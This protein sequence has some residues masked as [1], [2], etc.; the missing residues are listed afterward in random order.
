MNRKT[1]ILIVTES[2]VP[3]GAETVVLDLAKNIDRDRFNV[4][5]VLFRPGWLLD[6]LREAQVDVRLMESDRSFDLGFIMTL[7]RFCKENQIDLINS[8]LP[9]ANMYCA[10]IGKL[11]GLPVI[12]TAHNEFIMPG[13]EE[14][15]TSIKNFLTRSLA[16]KHVLVADYMKDQYI[17]A[18]K[19]TVDSIEII[20]NGIYFRPRPDEN[21]LLSL[22]QQLNFNQSDILI[23]NV[24]NFDPPKGHNHLVEAASIVCNENSLVK[25]LLIGDEREGEIADPLKE[26]VAALG[27][28]DKILFL[29]FR[30]DVA[31]LL[32]LLDIFVLPSISEGLPL[33]IIEAKAAAKPIVATNV[34]GV[35]EVVFDCQNGYLVPAGDESAMAERLIKLAGDTDLRKTMGLNG[36]DNARAIFS[37]ETMISSYQDLFVRMVDKT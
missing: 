6:Q 4:W 26:R 18:G 31:D 37:M 10:M 11:A 32:H 22:R 29:G 36:Y 30:A 7:R 3:G 12:T 16:T 20:R 28:T 5:V 27:L 9:G 15:F 2:S 35:S 1:N 19:Y 24:A 13:Y 23:G 14:R 17:T 8:H 34:G 25:F 21:I 33:S